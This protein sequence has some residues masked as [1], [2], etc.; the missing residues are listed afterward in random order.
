MAP[1]LL[2]Y[3]NC[4]WQKVLLTK[5]LALHSMPVRLIEAELP[6]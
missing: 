6:L 4:S 5:L 1:H 3:I 2:A